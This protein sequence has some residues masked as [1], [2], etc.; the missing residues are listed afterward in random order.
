MATM[1]DIAEKANV[2]IATVSR[3][4]NHDSTLSVGE[5]VK[6]KI[7]ETAE[8]LNY[9]KHISK[10]AKKQLRIAIVQWYTESEELNDMYYYSI[11]QGAEK[12]NRTQPA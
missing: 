12:K 10:I 6:K 8:Y 9:K 4:L 5:E 3:V 2:S 11:R 7:F 1:K